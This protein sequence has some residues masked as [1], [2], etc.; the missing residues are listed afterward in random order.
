MLNSSNAVEGLGWAGFD[1]L[2]LDGEHSPINLADAVSHL[3]ALSCTPTVPIVRTAWNDHV[4]LKQ[5]LD[6]GA[7]TIMIP[8]VQNAEEGR[9]AVASTRYPPEGR[10]GFAAMH[11][12]SRFGA[13]ADY[14]HHASETI[15]LIVQVETI[16]AIGEIEDIAAVPGIDA[17]FF[18]P[19]DLSASMGMLGRPGEPDITRKIE[20][21]AKKV[22]AAGKAVGVLA[23][24]PD[25]AK[26]YMS[27]GFDFVSVTTDCSLLFGHARATARMFRSG[28][29]R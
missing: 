2:L 14:V 5:Y 3:R 20:D 6:I 26:H 27:A 17:V 28:E 21:A 9:S 18:G 7:Q 23:P 29:G 22:K 10:R 4:M 1:W 8:Y 16:S 13:I 11:R 15:F 24:N 25:L 12:A 19:G